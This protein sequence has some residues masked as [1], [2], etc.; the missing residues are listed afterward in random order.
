MTDFESVRTVGIL[1]DATHTDD[2]MVVSRM[3]EKLR[4][5][6]KDVTVLG[7]IRYKVKEDKE[8]YVFDA[9][10]INW[11]YVPRMD[12]VN[13]FMDAR[14]DLLISA[15]TGECLPLEYI[16]AGSKAHFRVGAYKRGK[17]YCSELMINAHDEFRLADLLDQIMHF[18]KAIRND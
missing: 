16:A 11:F 2:V 9:T 5:E 13:R 6:G 3:A 18:T 1:F 14:F 8:D 10:D 12:R 15:F 4:E 7:H 17:T